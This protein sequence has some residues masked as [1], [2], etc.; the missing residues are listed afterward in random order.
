MLIKNQ[1]RSAVHPQKN[2]FRYYEGSFGEFIAKWVEERAVRDSA[3]R[4]A[5]EE[6]TSLRQCVE[7]ESDEHSFTAIFK[8]TKGVHI[9]VWEGSKRGI[10]HV[11]L[12]GGSRQLYGVSDLLGIIGVMAGTKAAGRNS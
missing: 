8:A 12:N 7:S 4:E 1:H 10:F 6:L 2:D 5:I 11:G 9:R 3:R